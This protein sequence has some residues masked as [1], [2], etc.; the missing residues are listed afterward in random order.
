MP[1]WRCEVSLEVWD[2]LRHATVLWPP[3]PMQIQP[4]GSE[5]RGTGE[6]FVLCGCGV[7]SPE[8]SI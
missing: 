2:V 8:F 6:Y 3:A 7:R 1:K 5:L 4:G